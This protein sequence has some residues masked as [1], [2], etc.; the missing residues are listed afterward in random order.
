MQKNPKK[1]QQKKRFGLP[2]YIQSTPSLSSKLSK[3]SSTKA[4]PQM[5]P[6]N[7]LMKNH[8]FQMK[9]RVT[10]T[11]ENV[12]NISC[13]GFDFVCL[14]FFFFVF[15][16]KK[17]FL[18]KTLFYWEL[19]CDMQMEHVWCVHY[20]QWVTWVQ[21]G[22]DGGGKWMKGTVKIIFIFILQWNRKLWNWRTNRADVVKWCLQGWHG[23][24][25]R[26]SATT[27]IHLCLCWL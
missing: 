9:F 4:K 16:I 20:G 22:G 15:L 25:P 10:K 14:D 1:Q 19:F 24:E 7:K 26:N 8:H 11:R 27:G 18:K 12:K 6:E 13:S 23:K 3:F 21:L 5:S 17:W 2:H